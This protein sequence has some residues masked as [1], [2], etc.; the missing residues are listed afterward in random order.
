MALHTLEDA[1]VEELRDILNAERQLT[2]ALPKMAKGAADEKL[3]EAIERHLEETQ[4]QVERLEQVFKLLGKPA[5][6][7]SCEAMEGL[8]A[9]GAEVLEEDAEEPVLDALLIASAQKVEHYEIATYGTLC[10]WA[11]TLGLD[12]AAELLKQ[13][14]AEEKNADETLSQIAAEI[15]LAAAEGA[16]AEAN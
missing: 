2:K 9:E 15:N 14:L 13:N 16:M 7:K 8:I 4:G 3:Q 12:E 10:T 6:G 11:E 5:R 1:F